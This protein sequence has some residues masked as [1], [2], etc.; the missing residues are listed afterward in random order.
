MRLHRAA[1]GPIR[2]ALRGQQDER[3]AFA[4][5]KRFILPRPKFVLDGEARGKTPL[6]IASLERGDAAPSSQHRPNPDV[7]VQVVGQQWSWT[8]NHTVDPKD[9]DGPVVYTSGTASQIPTLVLPVDQTIEFKLSSPDV[10][11]SFWIPAFLFKMD[12]IPG[13]DGD[14]RNSFQV[15]TIKEGTFAGK[16][17]ELCGVYHSRM[18]FNVEV[19]SQDEYQSYL[20]EQRAEGFEAD[21]PLLGGADAR[22]QAGLAE[23]TQNSNN[24]G[25]E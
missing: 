23:A 2:R 10:I 8:F 1:F 7:V 19:V 5:Q 18:I 4:Q 3:L 9:L 20:D 12:V 16:C 15:K 6:P 22:T 11:H 13:Q 25:D 21:R 17:A 24:G 14:E